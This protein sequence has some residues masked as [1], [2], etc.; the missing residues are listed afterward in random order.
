MTS[1]RDRRSVRLQEFDYGAQGAYLIA[2]STHQRGCLFGEVVGDAI[3][4]SPLGEIAAACWEQIPNHFPHADLDAWVVM[5]N[6]IHGILILEDRRGTPWRAPTRFE[7]FGRPVA[8]SVPTIVR[9]YKAAVTA[10]AR[11]EGLAREVWQ[12]NYYEHVLRSD[13]DVQ[14]ARGYITNNPAR[15][16]MDRENPARHR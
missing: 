4:L 12:R 9:S 5:P 13:E 11:R 2:I 8:G 6:H 1:A 3:A 14:R 15:W 16:A 10:R 7:R